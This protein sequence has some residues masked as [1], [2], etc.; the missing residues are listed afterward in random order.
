MK[1]TVMED[2]L[3]FP[4]DKPVLP[5]GLNVLTIL[6]Y[7]GCSFSFILLFAIGPLYR[8]LLKIMDKAAESGKEMSAKELEDMRKGK[9]AM[10]LMLANL[11]PIIITGLIGVVLC[12]IGALWMRKFKKDGFWLY[13]IGELMPPIASIVILGSPQ[14]TGFWPIFFNIVFPLAFVILYATQRKYLTK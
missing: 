4:G 10:N 8:F 5:T 2:K 9:E 13:T 7:I 6:T 12:F 3:N 11:T 14:L 1:I